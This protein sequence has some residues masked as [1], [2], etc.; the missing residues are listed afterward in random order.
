MRADEKIALLRDGFPIIPVRFTLDMA[1]DS[2]PREGETLHSV[3]VDH[4]S[5]PRRPLRIEQFPA[6]E[7]VGSVQWTQSL[8]SI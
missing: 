6:F 5:D 2:S 4:F 7:F 8:D 1:L 3:S